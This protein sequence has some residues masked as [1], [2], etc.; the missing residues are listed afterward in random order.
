MTT[1]AKSTTLERSTDLA[2]IAQD[3]AVVAARAAVDAAVAAR[4]RA[5]VEARTVRTVLAQ[6][7]AAGDGLAI[8]RARVALPRA[9]LAEMETDLA[10]QEATATSAQ[11][12]RAALAQRLPAARERVRRLVV[13]LYAVLD[14]EVMP[15]MLA[16]RDQ[17]T[18]ENTALGRPL[19][20][21]GELLWPEFLGPTPGDSLF[22]LRRTLLTRSGWLE[23]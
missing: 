7:P 15:L 22:E 23:G 17:I 10:F 18:R 3:P 13:Q 19:I 12:E 2:P 6:P 16:L 21:L 11:V 1:M 4:D 9:E 14:G 8:L 5:S 20:P